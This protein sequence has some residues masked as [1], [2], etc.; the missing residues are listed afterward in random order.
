MTNKDKWVWVETV[1][2]VILLFAFIVR[3]EAS[4]VFAI[5]A[6]LLMALFVSD[7]L[8]KGFIRAMRSLPSRIWKVIRMLPP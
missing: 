3:G 4:L 6:S 2:M 5:G 8:R 1:V 7:I